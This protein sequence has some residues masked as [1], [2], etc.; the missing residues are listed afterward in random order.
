[1]Q[2]KKNS[3][4]RHSQDM[5]DLGG[6]NFRNQFNVLRE[7]ELS[8]STCGAY[9]ED[10]STSTKLLRKRSAMEDDMEEVEEENIDEGVGSEK[11]KIKMHSSSNNHLTPHG[12]R[13]F[14]M[15]KD[16]TSP[17]PGNQQLQSTQE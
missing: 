3:A 17:A 6:L 11:K 13:A 10:A 4:Q 2:S 15:S 5:K 7:E 1:M 16:R 8:I 12:P 9:D 14:Q